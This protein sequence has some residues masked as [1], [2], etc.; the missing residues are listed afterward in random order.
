MIICFVAPGGAGK[1]TVINK[2]LQL[3]SDIFRKPV[4]YSSREMRPGE[5]DG[6]DYHFKSQNEILAL[7]DL[8]AVHTTSDGIIY[9]DRISELMPQKGMVTLT[10]IRPDGMEELQ[11]HGMNTLAVF[12]ELD[13]LECRRRMLLRGDESSQVERR[14][15]RDKRESE[16]LQ[17]TFSHRKIVVDASNSIDQVISE[18]LKKLGESMLLKSL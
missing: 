7:Q 13:E 5:I 1:T 2:L 9:A 10:T 15:I 18:V 4:S 12:L 14:L 16:Q 17:T 8:V 3:N 6:I 11:K